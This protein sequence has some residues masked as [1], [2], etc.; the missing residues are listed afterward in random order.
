MSE[1]DG[2]VER[3]EWVDGRFAYR[4][5]EHAGFSRVERGGAGKGVRVF[6]G[7]FVCDDAAT[8]R[9]ILN[10]ATQLRERDE[11]IAELEQNIGRVSDER[12]AE[13]I[14][15]ESAEASAEDAERGLAEAEKA[16]GMVARHPHAGF[17]MRA[18]VGDL[19]D[20]KRFQ[21]LPAV[22][23]ALGEGK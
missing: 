12:R 7:V 14:R 5:T 22:Q 8:V 18:N 9:E 6:A 23:R 4:A 15:A 3:H 20:G 19:K 10:L 21:D 13:W 2:R 11:R 1:S 16:L 17:L